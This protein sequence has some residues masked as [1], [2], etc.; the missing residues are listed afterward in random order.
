M[1][2][3]GTDRVGMIGLGRMGG[4]ICRRLAE[5]GAPLVVY[6]ANETTLESYRDVAETGADVS[7]VLRRC[8]LLFLSL[9]GSPQVEQTAD[10]LLRGGGA[11][12]KTVVDLSTSLPA[13]TRRLYDRFRAA[14]ADFAD[15][16]LTGTPAHA[17]EGKLIVTFGGD[18]DV[19]E[20]LRPTVSLF[21]RAFHRIGNAGAGH[22]AKLANNY[23]AI[24]YIALYAEVFPLLEKMEEELDISA[25]EL[26]DIIGQSSVDCAMYRNAGAKIVKKTY[27]PSFAL[28]LALKDLSYL[29][30]VFGEYGSP[31]YVLDGGLNLLMTAER[32]GYGGG[33]VSEMA[34]LTRA[35][36]GMGEP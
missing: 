20:R 1:D 25:A 32:R 18:R 15:A 21:S 5:Q 22:I 12:G 2:R 4:G 34:R 36:L 17:R 11:A 31:S 23:L 30:T 28:P 33:D 7:D 9:P 26:Y 3:M 14:G 24:M 10:A 27:D 35:H 19:F 8:D 13:S 6:D 16:A 29:K